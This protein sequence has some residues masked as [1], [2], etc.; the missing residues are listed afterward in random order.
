MRRLGRRQ[1]LQ[2]LRPSD[3]RIDLCWD[4]IQMGAAA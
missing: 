2:G 4:Y 1:G 3:P